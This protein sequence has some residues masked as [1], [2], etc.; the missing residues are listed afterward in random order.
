MIQVTFL[1]TSAA[2]PTVDRNVAG[3]MLQRAGES[4]LFDC[5]EGTQRQMMRHGTGFLV[6]D[7]F[8]TH[9][10]AD[11]TLGIPGLLRGMAMQARTAPL[12]IYGPRSAEAQIG[13]LVALG[14]DRPKFPVEI[15]EL[16]AGDVLPRGDYDLVVGEASHKGECLAYAV[17][18]HARLGRFD[19]T[20][21]RALGIPEGPLWGKL[22]KG[23]SVPDATGRMVTSAELVGPPRP[24][25]KVVYSG[26]TVP[27]AS[28]RML[29]KDAD[30]LIHEA[31]FGEDERERALETRHST[32]RD[33]AT[34][35]RDAN[36]KQL[37]LTHI[38]ARY[39]REAP[40][41]AAE[42]RAV[43]P[44]TKV[45]KDGVVVEVAYDDDR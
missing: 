7:V 10:H 6:H 29:A 31:T 14:M 38:S 25:L 21:A 16:K 19:P 12:R 4:L 15:I 39:S 23:E 22:H 8:L 40:E 41:L 30:L 13:P 18:E 26:D 42:A 17:V 11:H 24:G 44:E 1:G 36:V 34:V 45:A 37:W 20:V 5:G 3:L 2:V 33:A 9:Y 28:V 35:A 43:F 32:A 27:C